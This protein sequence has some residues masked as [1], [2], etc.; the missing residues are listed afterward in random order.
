MKYL[1]FTTCLW[2]FSFSLIGVYLSGQVDAWFSVVSRIAIASLVFLPF[3]RLKGLPLLLILKLMA[4]GAFQLGIMYCFY[5]QSF[6]YLSVP[7]VLLFTV[8]TPIYVTLIY[9]LYHKRFS[10]LYLGT[11]S[12]AVIGAIII[13]FVL[14]NPHFLKGFLII[15]GANVCF[16]IGQ[17]SYKVLIERESLALKQHQVF[18]WFY[19]GALCITLPAFCLLGDSSKLPTT[20]IQWAIIIYLGAIA[21]GL[22]YFLWNKGATLVSSGTL[23]VMN[24][25]LI[26]AGILVNVLF[27][28]KDADLVTLCIGAI[29][30]ITSVGLTEKVAKSQKLFHS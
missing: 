22:G 7:E 21:S 6:L 5:Y 29:V 1:S 16:A 3:L 8:F 30:I 15:Q 10:L 20:H 27:W 12:L 18:A 4:I 19:L 14:V 25:V 13:Q 17:V 2:A 11:A 26:P 23:A 28:N 9:D 24:N